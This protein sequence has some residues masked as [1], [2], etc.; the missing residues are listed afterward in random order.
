MNLLEDVTV[1]RKRDPSSCPICGL[2]ISPGDLQTHFVHEL[3]RLYKLSGT[4]LATGRKRRNE[5]TR[6]PAL[7]GDNGP[8]G[9]WEVNKIGRRNVQNVHTFAFQ[10]FQR[11]KINRQGRLRLKV[12]KRKSDDCPMCIEHLHRISEGITV[13][14]QCPRKVLLPLVCSYF[15]NYNIHF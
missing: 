8:E 12:R 15:K 14:E 7:P 3:E 11:I 1:K 10:T 2:T 5:T 4:G 13:H 9:R 6:S